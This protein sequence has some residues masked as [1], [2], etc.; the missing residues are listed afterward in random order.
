MRAPEN[1]DDVIVTV[2]RP[3]GVVDVSLPEW[4]RIGPGPRP[5]VGICRARWR[6]GEPVPLEEIPLELHDS[7]LSRERQR[8]GEL[9]IVWGQ[10][11]DE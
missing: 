7:P 8:R 10:P 3:A 9:P 6:S 5:L 11:P 2:L 4:I 1:Y